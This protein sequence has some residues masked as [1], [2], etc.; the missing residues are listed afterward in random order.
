MCKNKYAKRVLAAY[1]EIP[2]FTAGEMA[3]IRATNRLDVA[4]FRDANTD[5]RHP[6]RA[7]A[8]AAANKVCMILS[9][10]ALPITRAAKG[11]RIYKILINGEGRPVY[12]HESDLKRPR[13]VKK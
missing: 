3:Q 4:N 12:A 9:A 6:N 11:A 1:G 8:R 2:K 13:G 5:H 7:S 10:D